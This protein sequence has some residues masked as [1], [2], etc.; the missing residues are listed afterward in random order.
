MNE[1]LFVRAKGGGPS[2]EGGL[3]QVSTLDT[4]A[5]LLSELWRS[6]EAISMAQ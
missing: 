6:K 4:V 5:L 1:F 2:C 3:S